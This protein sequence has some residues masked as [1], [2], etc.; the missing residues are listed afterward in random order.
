MGLTAWFGFPKLH[1]P[2][3]TAK[4]AKTDLVLSEENTPRGQRAKGYVQKTYPGSDNLQA[5]HIA[6][7]NSFDP[8]ELDA[9]G[10][11]LN[12]FIIFY[13]LK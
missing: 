6:D 7:Q 5:Q 3:A 10:L 2:P 1:G 9:N 8:S 12:V 13:R 4:V 11:L